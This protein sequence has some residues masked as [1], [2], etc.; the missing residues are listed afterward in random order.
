M[1]LLI[2]LAGAG[3]SFALAGCA[4]PAAQSTRQKLA[5]RDL[6]GALADYRAWRTQQGGEDKTALRAMALQVLWSATKAE[7]PAARRA[8]IAA[9]YDL[10]LAEMAEPVSRLLDDDDDRVRADAAAALVKAHPDAGMVLGESLESPE[11]EAR[12]TAL[13]A[14]ADRIG[15]RAHDDIATHLSDAD[16]TVRAAACAALARTSSEKTR[17]ADVAAL[18]ER[19]R[20][21]ADGPVRAQ[22]LRSLVGLAPAEALTVARGR[23]QDPYLGV[24]LAVVHALAAVGEA[25][26]DELTAQARG[27]DLFVALRAG[28]AVAKRGDVIPAL[29]AIDRASAAPEWTVRAAAANAMT[30]VGRATG[31]WPR[32]AR[33]G[34]DPEV[35]VRLAAAR[36]YLALGRDDDGRAIL[37]AALADP[38]EAVRLDAAIDLAALGDVR[39]RDTLEALMAASDVGVRAGA[40]EAVRGRA[41]VSDALL[42]LL[43]DPAW[44]VRVAAAWTILS[45]L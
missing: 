39:G 14:L 30:G 17:A 16:G 28:V 37:L 13:R 18:G 24:R 19:A 31:A 11:P 7:D 44:R 29:A 12:I 2:L 23:A 32:L 22:A 20:S 34:A 10:D 25:G 33:L 43:V 3:A 6:P 9:A 8:A 42:A 15:P 45:L 26:R 41:A 38:S 35:A 1:P 40:A 36:A 5:D 4:G 27:Q 21:D